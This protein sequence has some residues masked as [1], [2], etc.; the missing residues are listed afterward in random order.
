MH[1]RLTRYSDDLLA[2]KILGLGIIGLGTSDIEGK[3]AISAA[4]T[5]SS[6]SSTCGAP[7]AACARSRR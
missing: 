7:R 3:I 5:S 6:A 2:H 4:A 1:V